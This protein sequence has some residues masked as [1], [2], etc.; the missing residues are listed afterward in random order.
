MKKIFAVSLFIALVSLFVGG[1]VFAAQIQIQKNGSYDLAKGQTVNDNLYAMGGNISVSGNVNGDLTAFGGTVLVSGDTQRDLAGAGGTLDISGNVGDDLRAAGGTIISS[2]RVGGDVLLGGGQITLTDNS[3]VAKDLLIGGS[4]VTIGGLVNGYAKISGNNVVIN[5]HIKG[6][7]RVYAKKLIISQGAVLDNG[8]TYNSPVAAQI[9]QGA[10]VKG[11]VVFNEVK[12]KT[13]GMNFSLWPAFG[14][15]WLLKL[16]MAI[17]LGLVLLWLFNRQA[18]D[19][20]K[21]SLKE[22]GWNLLRGFVLMILLPITAAILFI[23][24][25]GVPFGA[26]ILLLMILGSILAWVLA[27]AFIGS[28]LLK[29]FKRSSDY[30]VDW[31]TVV[32]GIV[33]FS[34]VSLIPFVGWLVGF[35]AFLI[36]FGAVFT[37]AYQG[38]KKIR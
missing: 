32:I 5:G 4:S 11:N 27:G 25:I 8:L 23:T 24:V 2:S 18:K 15:L 6:P 38:A 16:V 35:L 34:L 19:L 1:P 31:W 12:N 29:M 3:S 28:W 33:V 10:Q 20:V 17:L 36:A 13:A 37:S 7:V 14:I 26:I 9:E 22:Y 21:I 30:E